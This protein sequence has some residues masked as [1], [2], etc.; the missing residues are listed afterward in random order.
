MRKLKLLFYG[1][2]AFIMD[3]MSTTDLE[4]KIIK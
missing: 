1:K 4:T 2:K 3:E